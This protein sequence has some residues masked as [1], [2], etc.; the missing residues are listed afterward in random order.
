MLPLTYPILKHGLIEVLCIALMIIFTHF[1][2]QYSTSQHL[3]TIV[4]PTLKD[5]GSNTK[6]ATIARIMNDEDVQ[7]LWDIITAIDE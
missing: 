7:F 4:N 2:F 3:Q 6:D 1:F 5:L